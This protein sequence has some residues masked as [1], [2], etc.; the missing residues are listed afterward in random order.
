ME[1]VLRDHAIQ[2]CFFGLSYDE[3]AVIESTRWHPDKLMD[4][5]NGKQILLRADF[6]HAVERDL[7]SYLCLT[8]LVSQQQI[9]PSICGSILFQLSGHWQFVTSKDRCGST[10]L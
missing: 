2:F 3:L 9:L 4:C 10:A 7:K 8:I 5:T 6:V 1:V